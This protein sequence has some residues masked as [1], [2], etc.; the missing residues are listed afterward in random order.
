MAA[1][2]TT[3]KFHSSNSNPAVS[4]NKTAAPKK[5]QKIA[6]SSESIRASL[7]QTNLTRRHFLTLIGRVLSLLKQS[8]AVTIPLHQGATISEATLQEI[9]REIMLLIGK[10]ANT[11]QL[12]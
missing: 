6:T 7:S 10:P 2:I 8:V 3:C 12:H 1:I 4:K 11:I 9:E 5:L